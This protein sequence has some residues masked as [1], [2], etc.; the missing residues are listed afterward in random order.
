MLSN[1]GFVDRQC[2]NKGVELNMKTQL[3]TFAIN[4]GDQAGFDSLAET[5]L[6]PIGGSTLR[7]SSGSLTTRPTLS[8]N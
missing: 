6:M 3:V 1:L 8:I 4:S 5:T 2:F 7:F